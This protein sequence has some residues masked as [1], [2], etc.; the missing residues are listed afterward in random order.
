MSYYIAEASFK[1]MTLLPWSSESWEYRREDVSNSS[2]A[3][4]PS[5]SPRHPFSSC[6]SHI[7]CRI[8]SCYCGLENGCLSLKESTQL[9]EERRKPLV[10]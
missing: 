10:N 5:S 6:G 2:P 8:S 7:C 3:F 1:L 4:S 9:S